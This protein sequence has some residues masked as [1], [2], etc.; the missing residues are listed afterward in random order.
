MS[1]ASFPACGVGAADRQAHRRLPEVFAVMKSRLYG[2]SQRGSI[3]AAPLSRFNVTTVAA[4][5]P[6]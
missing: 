6:C 2:M 5:W 1:G 4:S 3:S